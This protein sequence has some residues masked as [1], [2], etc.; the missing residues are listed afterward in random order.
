MNSIQSAPIPTPYAKTMNMEKTAG[1]LCC[2]LCSGLAIGLPMLFREASKDLHTLMEEKVQEQALVIISANIPSWY[3]P[4][5][6][7]GKA[8]LNLK[9]D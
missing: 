2:V 6:A 5:S 1:L 8:P 7:R 3:V 9:Q 4:Y